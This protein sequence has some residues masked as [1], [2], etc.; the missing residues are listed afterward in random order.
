MCGGVLAQY[1]GSG[2][3]WYQWYH[4]R[5]MSIRYSYYVLTKYS[6]FDIVGI[7]EREHLTT[8]LD[9]TDDE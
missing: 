2:S 3:T 5:M 9:R 1:T 6:A 7:R 8:T 4:C